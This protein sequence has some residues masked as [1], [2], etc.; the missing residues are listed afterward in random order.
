MSPYI[1][2]RIIDMFKKQTQPKQ[3]YQL[4]AQEKNILSEVVLGF[5]K[6]VISKKLFI[7]YHTVDSHIRNIYKKLNVNNQIH[8][9]TKTIRENLV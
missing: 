4:T 1:A 2:T 7:S 5:S 9:V 3:D 6:K 8:M